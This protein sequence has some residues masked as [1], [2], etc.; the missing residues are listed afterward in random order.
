MRKARRKKLT[1]RAASAAVPRPEAGP[2]TIPPT[3][4][5]PAPMVPPP[6]RRI[7][8]GRLFAHGLVALVLLAAAWLRLSGAYWGD[9]G[10]HPDERGIYMR[11]DNLQVLPAPTDGIST[12]GGLARTL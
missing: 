2:S 6:R 4:T 10:M 7:S 9:Q 3:A 12:L 11:I 1:T 5:E 8:G